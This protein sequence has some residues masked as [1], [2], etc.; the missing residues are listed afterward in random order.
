MPLTLSEQATDATLPPELAEVLQTAMAQPDL[1]GESPQED[2]E[3]AMSPEDKK[4]HDEIFLFPE[5]KP[6]LTALRDSFKTEKD[7]SKANRER[8]KINVDLETERAAKRIK[9][10]DVLVPMRVIDEGIAREKPG[11]IAYLQQSRRLAV[12]VDVQAPNTKHDDLEACFTRGM[13]YQDWIRSWYSIIDGGQLHGW[14]WLEVLYDATKPLHVGIE[15]VGHDRLVFPLDCEDIQNCT[16]IMREY[17][18]SK[19]Q[20]RTYVKQFGFDKEQ[21]DR[22][23]ATEGDS[24]LE[25]D[26]GAKD[27]TYSIYKLYCKYEGIVYVAWFSFEGGTDNWLKA[28][29]KFY[30]GVDKQVSVMVDGPMQTVMDEMGNI[31][32]VPGPQVPSLEWQSVDETLYPVVPFF[33]E[34]TEQKEISS[35]TGRAFKDKFKQ[36]VMTTGWSAFLNGLNRA[37][38]FVLAKDIADGKSASELQGVEI[39][40]GAILPS[41]A[42]QF[43]IAYPDP[44]IL[45]ALQ[46]FDSKIATSSGQ[47]TYAVQSKSSGARTTAR[48]VDSAEKDTNLLSSVNITLFA[49]TVRK[50]YNMGWNIVQSQALQDKIDF[51]GQMV[52][53]PSPMPTIDDQWKF[54]NNHEVIARK[55]DIRPAGDEDVIR[56][57]ELLAKM[58]AYWPIV[59]N[60]PIA[61]P[62]LSYMLK[63]EFAEQGDNWAKILEAGDP[64]VMVQQLVAVLMS[65]VKDGVF[66]IASLPPQ[67]QGQLQ[68][69]MQS[70]QQ[71]IQQ[72]QQQGQQNGQQG[73]PSSSNTGTTNGNSNNR[74]QLANSPGDEGA[75]NGS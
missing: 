69:L 15:H 63:I 21:T 29:M 73:I 18:L 9:P 2:A 51:Y 66:N 22:L 60:T 38:W 52:Q 33:Y 3:E 49:G 6:Y 71:M 13:Q 74:P 37:T 61:M 72:R 27:K 59:Q 7:I 57:Q 42:K 28:P 17:R 56:R 4:L 44:V 34:E 41:S 20:L 11:L 46:A 75:N 31:I 10:S 64:M 67:A 36:E 19:I 58:Q 54:E 16:R 68:M 62:F 32:Q 5:A 65:A 55:Y 25:G 12:F 45:N 43:T 40:D 14:D 35:K 53:V 8:R 1:M 39:K 50:A 24:K 26:T 48:E 30:N 70:A 47:M 23:L